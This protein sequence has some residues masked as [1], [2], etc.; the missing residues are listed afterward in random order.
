MLEKHSNIKKNQAN[1]W[2][3]I[4]I[5]VN[6]R[7]ETTNWRCCWVCYILVCIIFVIVT[8]QETTIYTVFLLNCLLL[9]IDSNEIIW[10]YAIIWN[11]ITKLHGIRCVHFSNV[12]LYSA[13]LLTKIRDSRKSAY[14]S[15]ILMCRK[16]TL[17]LS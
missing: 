3:S 5:A 11:K 13:H 9:N 17:F 16:N 6:Q 15:A 8:H 4:S 1:V 7:W 12:F 14:I 10:Y 2:N